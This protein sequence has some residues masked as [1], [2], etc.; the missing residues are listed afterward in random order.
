MIGL[1]SAAMAQPL[2]PQPTTVVPHH[3]PAGG[4]AQGDRRPTNQMAIVSLVAAIASFAILPFIGAVVAVITGPL[5]R[6]RIRQTGEEG[7]GLALAGLV[8]GYVHLGLFAL[9]IV[10]LLVVFGAI[11]FLVAAGSPR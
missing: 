5:A 3:Q 7:D 4:Y 6:T 8:I 2:G 10:V 1:H 11:G 9:L